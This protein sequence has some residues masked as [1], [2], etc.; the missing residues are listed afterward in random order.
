MVAF[1]REH[2]NLPW[3]IQIHETITNQRRAAKWQMCHSF[4][5]SCLYCFIF[6]SCTSDCIIKVWKRIFLSG[7]E[8]FKHGHSYYIYSYVNFKYDVV[9]PYS[10][11]SKTG[12]SFDNFITV[13]FCCQVNVL[14]LS[15]SCH[16]SFLVVFDFSSP[17]LVWLVTAL[18]RLN[19]LFKLGP[20]PLCPVLL[21]FGQCYALVRLKC[22][23]GFTLPAGQTF[24]C[25]F[26]EVLRSCWNR[27]DFR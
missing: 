26:I 20:L 6:T 2:T 9:R 19:V 3:N 7:S 12:Y 10:G 4:I 15:R 27:R 21:F 13:Y 23:A 16:A 11:W 25:G 5:S 17:A 14:L 18:N 8:I 1:C 22:L 24:S